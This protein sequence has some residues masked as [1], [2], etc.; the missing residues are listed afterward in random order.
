MR[1]A[2][3]ASVGDL[4]LVWSV[5]IIRIGHVPTIKEFRPKKGLKL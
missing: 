4:D 2:L 5:I 1:A 3:A